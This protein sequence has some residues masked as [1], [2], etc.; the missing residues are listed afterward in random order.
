MADVALATT[1][2]K[3]ITTLEGTLPLTP[4]LVQR[5]LQNERK[6]VV[7]TN[8]TFYL[9]FFFYSSSDYRQ[10]VGTSPVT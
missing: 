5:F 3:M 9:V 1:T 7:G 2:F 10:K 6:I 8:G 4:Q